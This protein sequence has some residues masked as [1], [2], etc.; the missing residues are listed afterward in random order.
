MALESLERD[1]MPLGSLHV[2]LQYGGQRSLKK[3][4]LLQSVLCRQHWFLHQPFILSK[5]SDRGCKNMNRL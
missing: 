5:Y 4:N 2:H 1:C 3:Q